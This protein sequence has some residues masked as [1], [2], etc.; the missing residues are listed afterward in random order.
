VAVPLSTYRSTP[1]PVTRM[2]GLLIG[3]NSVGR[4][5]LN[6]C[7]MSFEDIS[8]LSSEAQR[9]GSLHDAYLRNVERLGLV[10]ERRSREKGCGCYHVFNAMLIDTCEAQKADEKKKTLLDQIWIIARR[11]AGAVEKVLKARGRS[12]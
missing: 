2:G 1:A 7:A 3:A 11:M 12:S 9:H 8:G 4:R 10:G 5:T 6:V